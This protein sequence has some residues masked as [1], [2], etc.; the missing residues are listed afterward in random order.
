MQSEGQFGADSRQ[1]R[2]GLNSLRGTRRPA[3]RRRLGPR[4]CMTSS[5]INRRTNARHTIR[6]M[7][8]LLGERANLGRH[9][10]LSNTE[11]RD[12]QGAVAAWNVKSEAF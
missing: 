4:P 1:V 8:E 10:Q 2:G 3:R 9:G 7:H 12:G 11:L 6:L 5:T